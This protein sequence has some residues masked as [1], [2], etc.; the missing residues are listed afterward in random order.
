MS[1]QDYA[2][3]RRESAPPEWVELQGYLEQLPH[4]W[5]EKTLPLCERVGD[6]IRLQYKLLRLS[7]ETVEN[8]HMD[9]RYLLFDVE[10]TCRERDDLLR[11]LGIGG[12][13]EME[14]E[15]DF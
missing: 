11:E 1:R 5:R 14:S 3:R 2:D 15:S 12:D 10:A 13:D 8:L 9:V 6:Y 7:Q 4:A